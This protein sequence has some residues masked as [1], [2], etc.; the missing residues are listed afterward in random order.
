[1]SQHDVETESLP[2][3]VSICQER[4]RALNARL[5]RVEAGMDKIEVMIQ[6]IHSKLDRLALSQNHKWDYTQLAIISS[7]AGLCFYLIVQIL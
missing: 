6:D 5:E 3:H 2:A 1:V 7:L 4:Y